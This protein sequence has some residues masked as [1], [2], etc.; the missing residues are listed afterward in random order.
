MF[1]LNL[2]KRKQNKSD[3][4]FQEEIAF[5]GKDNS[6]IFDSKVNNGQEI[7]NI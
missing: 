1:L 5:N 3:H 7:N 6:N 4:S 2:F